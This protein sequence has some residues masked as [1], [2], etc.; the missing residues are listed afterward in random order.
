MLEKINTNPNYGKSPKTLT[1]PEKFYKRCSCCRDLTIAEEL[2]LLT[3]PWFDNYDSSY[4]QLVIEPFLYALCF[5]SAYPYLSKILPNFPPEILQLI[6][7]HKWSGMD[8][9]KITVYYAYN[10]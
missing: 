4:V 5:E 2:A 1:W 3:E 9:Q 6:Y 7:N 8:I 10:Q